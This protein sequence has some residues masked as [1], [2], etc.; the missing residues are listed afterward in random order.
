M[1]RKA[2]RVFFWVFAATFISTFGETIPQSFQPLFLFRLGISA[3][4]I[5]LVYNIKNVVQTFFRIPIGALSDKLGRKNLMVLGL[6]FISLVPLIYSVSYSAHLPLVA[7]LVSGLGVSIYFPPSEAYASGLFP[8]QKVGEALGRYHLSWSISA[9]IG[10]SVGG[11]LALIFPEYRPVFVLAGLITSISVLI[12][13]LKIEEDSNPSCPVNVYGEVVHLLRSL[14]SDMIRLMGNRRVMVGSVSVFAHSFCHWMLATFVPLFAA[15]VGFDEVTIGLSLT[16]NALLI[17][18]SLLFTGSLSDR[19]GRFPPIFLGLMLSV[20]AFALI[21]SVTEWWMLVG[22]MAL[23]GVSA[24]LV[25]PISQ[26]ATLE[27]LPVQE[28]GAV[29]GVWGTVMSLGGTVGLFA[30]SFI[31]SVAPIAWV[32]YFSSAFSFASALLIFAMRGYF[33]S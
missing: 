3:T 9:I 31:V 12:L 25:F 26:A 22:L 15:G 28:R 10:P 1:D 19:V 16:A 33:S 2:Q 17:A 24:A 5:G 32:F 13:F 4:V 14:P 6:A 11:F 18:L 23:L 20:G 30:M 8:P 21:P 27:A 29:T 7:M